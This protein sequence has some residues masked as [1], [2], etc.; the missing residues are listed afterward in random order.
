MSENEKTLNYFIEMST[1]LQDLIDEDCIIGIG[2]T[3]TFLKYLPGKELDVKAVEGAP[4]KKGDVM[5]RCLQENKKI[6]EI[7]PK[8]IFGIPFKS[9]T[10]PIKNHQ[11]N[12]VGTISIGRSLKRQHRHTELIENIA[13]ALEEITANIDEISSSA[14]E[15]AVSSEET[16]TQSKNAMLQMSQ[17]DTILKYIKN[18]SD[19]TNLL[20]LNAA[21]EAAKAGEQGRGFSVVAER[22]RKLSVETTNSVTNINNILQSIKESVSKMHEVIETTTGA[23]KIQSENAEQILGALEELNANT[24]LLADL[25]KEL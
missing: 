22:I 14:N 2:D 5:Y 13:A 11:G 25:S 4:L 15:I 20:G 19:E 1:Y 8:E 3:E 16:S 17:S 7:I 24:Q 12:P 6:V 9:V 18:I 21:I 10:I 23:T